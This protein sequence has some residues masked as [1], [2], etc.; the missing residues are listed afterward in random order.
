[1]R[2]PPFRFCVCGCLKVWARG[3]ALWEAMQGKTWAMWGERKNKNE[4]WNIQ[5]W[6][7]GNGRLAYVW[8]GQNMWGSINGWDW[9][10]ANHKSA[11]RRG[12]KEQNYVGVEWTR[13]L[14]R[15]CDKSYD[16]LISALTLLQTGPWTWC[17]SWR[18]GWRPSLSVLSL[19]RRCEPAA[20]FSGRQGKRQS[21]DRKISKTTVTDSKWHRLQSSD[22]I[23]SFVVLLDFLDVQQQSPGLTSELQRDAFIHTF[24][25]LHTHVKEPQK[26]TI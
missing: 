11:F 26:D 12:Q 20:S 8:D 5:M 17:G 25:Q 9:L 3:H 22:L 24:H 1:M 15:R 7:T 23:F 10:R 19:L 14:T 13:S 21:D 16:A 2:K 4:L 18:F 6:Q